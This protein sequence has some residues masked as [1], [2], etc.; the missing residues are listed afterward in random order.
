MRGGNLSGL[1]LCGGELWTVSDRDDDLLYRL[2]T[3]NRV[4]KAEGV[5]LQVPAV[6]DSGLPWS[7]SEEPFAVAIWT[8][9][10]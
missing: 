10:V 1:A 8:S 5:G 3:S 7:R 6:P 2:D 4:W 9:R